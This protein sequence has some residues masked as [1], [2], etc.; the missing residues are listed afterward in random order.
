[1]SNQDSLSL[2][3][4]AQLLGEEAGDRD[5]PQEALVPSDSPAVVRALHA[6]TSMTGPVISQH[7]EAQARQENHQLEPASSGLEIRQQAL[8]HQAEPHVSDE[9]SAPPRTS[10]RLHSVA[11]TVRADRKLAR[12]AG[13][14]ILGLTLLTS[15]FVLGRG[16]IAHST[17]GSEIVQNVLSA[18]VRSLRKELT[19][20]QDQIAILSTTLKNSEQTL[21]GRTT[22]PF[23]AQQLF[24]P[25]LS[26]RTSES[27]DSQ[28]HAPEPTAVELDVALE[29]IFRLNSKL[30]SLDAIAETLTNEME[31]AGQP[32]E[33]SS[34]N[35]RESA[36]VLPNKAESSS[37]DGA[38]KTSRVRMLSM[39][40]PLPAAPKPRRA[41]ERF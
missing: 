39:S 9:P 24:G 26:S 2:A 17:P 4:I 34:R 38:G 25:G 8:G 3:E 6:F 18:H 14:L 30:R 11:E 31:Q 32:G 22:D 33:A 40:T 5:E 35:S 41:L 16:E 19:E 20:A 15:G 13:L 21:N 37:V 27:A 29:R 36:A 1:M 10:L 7:E 12:R 23:R 28:H